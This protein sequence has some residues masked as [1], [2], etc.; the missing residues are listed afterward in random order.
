NKLVSGH[1]DSAETWRMLAQ[2]YDAQ[3]K[4]EQA[5]RAYSRALEADPK[6]V[7][8]YIALAEFAS[9][10]GN[11]DFALQ[12]VAQGIERLPE[13]AELRFEHGIVLGFRGDHVGADASFANAAA[14][15]PS[16]N[17]PLLALAVSHMESGDVAGAADI[18]GKARSADPADARAYYLYALAL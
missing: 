12:V 3:K 1:K 10:H 6:S 15:K 16:W 11:N 14:L 17:L 4:P 18:A 7:D 13:S 5:Y 2:A 8:T 9:A